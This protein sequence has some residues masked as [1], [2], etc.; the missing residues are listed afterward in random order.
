MITHVNEDEIFD[1][2]LRV[3]SGGQLTEKDLEA[4]E[5]VKECTE[6]YEKFCVAAAVCAAT[7][8][9]AMEAVAGMRRAERSAASVP[10]KH[11][12]VIEVVRRK[13]DDVRTA[14]MEQI[15][16]L[17]DSLTFEPALAMAAR[18]DGDNRVPGIVKL[19]ELDD[20]RTFVVFNAGQNNLY[21]QIDM[22]NMPDKKLGVFLMFR[23]NRILE[24][25]VTKDGNLL[26]GQM[27]DLPEGNFRIYIDA[28]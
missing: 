3:S 14:V 24:V 21:I 18:G 4:I 16:S 13:I 15:D 22:K 8:G 27:N 20:E 9:E 19:E 23:D 11:V 17:S 1:L 10:A 25:P 5:H 28:E 7:S 12:S 2:A 26:K 6:C